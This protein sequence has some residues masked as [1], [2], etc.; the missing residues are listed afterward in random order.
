MDRRHFNGQD[1]RFAFVDADGGER[2]F[3]SEQIERAVRDVSA[4]FEGVLAQGAEAV[5]VDLPNCP[6]F[7]WTLLACARSGLVL[8]ALN[9]RLSK[10]EKDLRLS[11]LEGK[12]RVDMVVD[13]RWARSLGVDEPVEIANAAS[14]PGPLVDGASS[15]G[16]IA[17]LPSVVGDT[18][19]LVMFTSGTTG[20]PK[21]VQLTWGQLFA[22]AQAAND[23][24]GCGAESVWQA[25][26][27]LYHIGGLQV[28]LRSFLAGCPFVLYAR[29]D[30]ERLLDDAVR[31][32]VTHLSVVD[33]ILQ[34]L[35]SAD[36]GRRAPV[37]PSYRCLLLGGAALNERTLAAARA[38]RARV[39]ASYGMTET[40]SLVASRLV[41]ELFDG[42]LSMLRGT[43]ARVVQPD[44]NGVGEL[45]LRGPSIASKYL[46]APM[47]VTVDGFFLTGDRARVDG[48]LLYVSERVG[49]MF[50]SGGENVYPAEVERCIN[51]VEGV[52][53]SYVFGMPDETWGRRPVAIVESPLDPELVESRVRARV[54]ERLAGF[55][56]PR[57]IV[58][59]SQMPRT[60]IGKIDRAAARA[61]AGC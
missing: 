22:S 19:A 51:G 6:L 54:A 27:P 24:L 11:Q 38:A 61:L 1:Y 25:V 46:N 41:D 59:V 44:E 13:E 50:V 35:I 15:E 58:V 5:A 47:R 34:D 26:L 48:G 30:A 32:G 20:V 18:P 55:C 43:E 33:K 2:F 16:V 53:A 10:A 3:T 14:E 57:R 42:G 4:R 12:L 23:S 52:S 21:A 45:A 40:A 60:G 29:C 39:H 28:V 9:H 37:L 49:D 17:E 8:V 31:F 56:R 36:E 7:V